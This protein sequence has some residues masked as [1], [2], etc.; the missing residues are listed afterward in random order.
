[1]CCNVFAGWAATLKFHADVQ[2]QLS[3]FYQREDTFSLGVCNGCQLMA[4]MG[5]V[6]PDEQGRS[7]KKE[8]WDYIALIL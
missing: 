5:W 8:V 6:A 2:A 3:A 1:M 4:L 7:H